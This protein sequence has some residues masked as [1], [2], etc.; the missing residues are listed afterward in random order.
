[1]ENEYNV[2]ML[3]KSG[4]AS[5]RLYHCLVAM[6]ISD[7]RE[8]ALIDDSIVL[9]QPNLGRKTFNEL[10]ELLVSLGIRRTSQGAIVNQANLQDTKVESIT[11]SA[12]VAQQYAI[13]AETPYLLIDLLVAIINTLFADKRNIEIIKL[14]LG[15]G[16]DK[17][18]RHTLQNIGDIYLITR[19]RV[20]QI[21]SKGM[22]KLHTTIR[23][24]RNAEAKQ[25][26]TICHAISGMDEADKADAIYDFCKCNYRDREPNALFGFIAWIVGVVPSWETGLSLA[27]SINNNRI[28]EGVHKDKEANKNEKLENTWAHLIYGAIFGEKL[29][30]FANHIPGMTNRAR[31]INTESEGVIGSFISSKMNKAIHYESSI[32]LRLFM[33]LERSPRVIWYQEQPTCIPYTIN[34]S[35]YKYYPDAAL[36]T[37]QGIGVVVE[38]KPIINMIH[39]LTV[40][41]AIAAIRNL[42][43]R[44]VGYL[45]TDMH[46]NTITSLANANSNIEFERA[47]LSIIDNMGMITW[48][49]LLLLEQKYNIGLKLFAGTVI[50]NNLAYYKEPFRISRLDGDLSF[51]ELRAP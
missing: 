43:E 21:Q 33:A 37:D 16:S 4:V 1:M 9:K 14:R 39:V 29:A 20:R 7:V 51:N 5:N 44:G 28:K 19:E 32:E 34:K 48:R 49:E 3:Y 22:D 26:A 6:S 46:G 45:L 31:M 47:I 13:S 30:S 18:E 12:D 38:T 50:R 25:V 10:V 2:H 23:T 11:S 42:R 17:I 15:I 40:I 35:S 41:K 8:M 36:I 27:K 24:G